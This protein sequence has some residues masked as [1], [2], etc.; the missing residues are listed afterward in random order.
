MSFSFETPT[1]RLYNYY[2]IGIEKPVIIQAG[3]KAEARLIIKKMASKLHPN[4]RGKRIIGETVVV[5][6]FGVTERMEN[7]KMLV[8]V[9]KESSPTGWMEKTEFKKKYY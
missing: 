1:I 7:G 8:W 5:P 9:G 2:F 4:Y 6:A 3:N